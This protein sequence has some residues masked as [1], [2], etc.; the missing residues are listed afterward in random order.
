MR[1]L[2]KATHKINR[3]CGNM[4]PWIDGTGQTSQ[5]TFKSMSAEFSLTLGYTVI[6]L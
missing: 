5:H 6:A 1:H 3:I 2:L 4:K